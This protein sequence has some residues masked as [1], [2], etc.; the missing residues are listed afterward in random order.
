MNWQLKQERE[1]N[2]RYITERYRQGAKVLEI[3]CNKVH[4]KGR[5]WWNLSTYD[6]RKFE[7]N[8]MLEHM[9]AQRLPTKFLYQH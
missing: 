3:N 9:D 8:L 7:T 4:F 5:P 6:R 1:N 2:R